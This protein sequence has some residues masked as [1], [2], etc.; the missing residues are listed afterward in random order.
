[1]TLVHAYSSYTLQTVENQTLAVLKQNITEQWL[2]VDGSQGAFNAYQI[3]VHL[4]IIALAFF[5]FF[6]FSVSGCKW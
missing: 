4:H 3:L 5:K 2:Y 1:M 6:W